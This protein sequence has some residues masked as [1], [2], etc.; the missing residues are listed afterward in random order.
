MDAARLR[1]S[2][3]F[4]E[5]SDADVERCAAWFQE[6]TLTA[7]SRLVNEGDYSHTFFVVLDGELEVRHDFEPVR[8]LGPGDFFGELG[9]LSDGRRSAKVI[10]LTRGAVARIMTWDFRT[11]LSEYPLIAARIEAVAGQRRHDD[12]IAASRRVDEEG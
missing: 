4:D 1:T 10:A 3:L 8:R 12:E 7:G 11:M 5:L 6:A 9:V 2:Y